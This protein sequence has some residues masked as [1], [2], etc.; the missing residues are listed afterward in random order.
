[1]TQ[2]TRRKA[3]DLAAQSN[4]CW[5]KERR[6]NPIECDIDKKRVVLADDDDDDDGEFIL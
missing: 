4:Y 5:D 1:M 3:D 2:R 6:G